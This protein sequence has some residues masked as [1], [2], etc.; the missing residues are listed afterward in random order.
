MQTRLKT[1]IA[2]LYATLVLVMGYATFAEQAHG[3]AFALGHIYHSWWFFGLWGLLAVGSVA[4]IW[5]HRLWQRIAVCMLHV[6]LLLILA[7]AAT[8]YVTSSDGQM[9]LRTGEQSSRYVRDDGKVQTLPFS[10]TLSK[11]DIIYYPGTQ[12]PQDFV[13]SIKLPSGE[14][15]TISMNHI[16]KHEGYR[17]YQSSFDPDLQGTV[18]SVRYDPY[19]TPLTYFAYALLG[20]SMMGVLLSRGEEFRRLLRSPLLRQ[21]TVGLLLLLPLSSEARSIPTI[22]ADEAQRAAR[23]Q[24]IYND[25]VAPLSTLAHD[26]LNKLYG[27]STYK[28][29]SAEQ[30]VYGW[31][32]RPDVWKAE[33][34][35][36]VKDKELRRELGVSSE[37]ISLS[38]LFSGDTYK[39]NSI[40]REGRQPTKAMRELDE[41]VGLILMLTEGQLIKPLPQG[42]PPLSDTRVEAEICYNQIPFCKVLF[43]TCLTLG[44]LA[45]FYM[46]Y[47]TGRSSQPQKRDWGWT[48]FTVCLWAV[49]LF[50][51]CGYLLHWYVAQ[52]IPLGNGYETMQFLALALLA[53][54]LL[55]CRRIRIILPFGFLL[56]G[57]ALLVA[58]L[59]QR[60]PQITPLMPVLSSPLLSA[61]VSIIMMS[62]A[63]LAFMMLNGLYA[64]LAGK[65]GS[66]QQLQLTL[67]NRLMLYPAVFFLAAGIFLGAVWANISWGKYWSWDPKE[68][69]A[70]ITLLIYAVP[71]HA[72]SLP[73]L[74]Q[75]KWFNLYL[76]LAFLTVLMT[77]FGVNYFLGGMHSY[78]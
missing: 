62:Y 19:G 36:R 70:L 53:L 71:L 45:F 52:R 42:T 75:P 60:N 8:T 24:V 12:A 32:A 73:A 23:M 39:L 47:R 28:G 26:F 2:L 21:A 77:Y 10:L 65:R 6:A 16:L 33:P 30:V 35:I 61:H 29:L 69:W 31:L 9:H 57:F 43:M 11:F 5:Q 54:T 27:K 55:L 78:A 64:L 40:L 22:N 58:W 44:F 49:F 51:L 7:G 3:T 25:R 14:E 38:Q 66:T 67:L 48:A 56:A 37:Y 15:V 59:G 1:L 20:L 18:L 17:F 13:S 76:T 63:L 4:Y 72:K 74:Q 41:K 46:L 50:H 68:T 34:M